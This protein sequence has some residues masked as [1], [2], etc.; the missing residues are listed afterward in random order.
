MLMAFFQT[1]NLWINQLAEGVAALVLDV[2]D[3]KVN[4][5]SPQVLAD[6]DQALDRVVN[7]GPFQVL[8]LKSGKPDNFC[9]GAD[10]Q[11]FKEDKKPEEYVAV[12]EK[13]QALFDKLANLQI[14]TVAVIAGA[15]LGG[16]LE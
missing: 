2:P 16:G 10:L 11:E 1:D 15:C 3:R 4:V 12:A 14:P 7:A 5:L 8:V 9:A 6:L 13:G